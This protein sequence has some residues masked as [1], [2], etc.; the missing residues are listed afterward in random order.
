MSYVPPFEDALSQEPWDDAVAAAAL[1]KTILVGI[2]SKAADGG[3]AGFDQFFGVID[4][5][6]RDEGIRI[7]LADGSHAWIPAQLNAV[8]R[9]REGVYSYRAM[10]EKVENPDLISNWTF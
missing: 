2:T 6:E 1:G 10:G 4:L 7:L 5:A 9:A 3:V 8:F